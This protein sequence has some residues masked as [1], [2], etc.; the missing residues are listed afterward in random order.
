[1]SAVL[2]HAVRR[3]LHTSIQRAGPQIE[4]PSAVSG[5]HEGGYKIWKNISLFVAFPAIALC[6]VNCYLQHLEHE[7]HAHEKHFTR[8]EYMTRREKRFPWGDGNHSLL[9]NPKTNPLPDGYET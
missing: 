2:N 4:G 6:G 9:H 1:M 3:F 8:Y 5:L 7:K